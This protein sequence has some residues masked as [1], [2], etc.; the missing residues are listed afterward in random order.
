MKAAIFTE[1]STTTSESTESYSDYF[2]GSFLSVNNLA[3]ELS[4]Y[5]DTEIHILSEV[6][7]YIRGEDSVHSKQSVDFDESSKNFK[8]SFLS[9]IGDLDVVV[10]LLTTDTFKHILAP[11]WD[12]TLEQSKLDSIWCIGTSRSGL[13][14]VNLEALESQH[15]VLI[16]QRRGVARV[17]TET[18]EEL[19]DHIRARLDD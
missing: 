19:I 17:G 15:P 14:S 5:C 16:Y 10:I 4:V 3:E 11:N 6:H 2:V 12:E 8:E 1:G 13:N 18:R 9:Q 7:G